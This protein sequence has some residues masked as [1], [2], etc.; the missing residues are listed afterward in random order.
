[1]NMQ[2]AIRSAPY[3]SDFYAKIAQGSPVEKLDAEMEK[4]LG[5]LDV[6]VTRMAAF[7]K[8]GGY[9]QV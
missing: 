9:G 4:W 6:I 2:V 7:L 5:A 8:D 1:M 3:R